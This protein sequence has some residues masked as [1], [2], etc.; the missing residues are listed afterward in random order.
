MTISKEVFLELWIG[1]IWRNSTWTEDNDWEDL[2]LW[3]KVTI[4]SESKERFCEIK[5]MEP[6]EIKLV[7]LLIQD[8]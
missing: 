2:R 7:L 6:N 1:D 5:W 4:R 3:D 8:L